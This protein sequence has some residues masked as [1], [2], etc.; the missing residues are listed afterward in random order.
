MRTIRRTAIAVLLS[1]LTFSPTAVNAETRADAA[2]ACWTETG[3][4]AWD[5]FYVRYKNCNPSG[6][7]VTLWATHDGVNEILVRGCGNVSAQ[8]VAIWK[9]LNGGNRTYRVIFCDAY[10][11]GTSYPDT[12]TWGIPGAE[13]GS[14]DYQVDKYKPW[15]SFSKSNLSPGEDF[16]IYYRPMSGPVR[17]VIPFSYDSQGGNVWTSLYEVAGVPNVSYW[18]MIHGNR[19]T[20][21][22][23]ALKVDFI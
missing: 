16:Y 7:K 6:V 1:L 21:Y 22:S 4:N 13:R 5:G 19:A 2:M 12:G 3:F 14:T 15:T 17:S 23:V 9:H 11:N 10:S 20:F 18:H 8:G